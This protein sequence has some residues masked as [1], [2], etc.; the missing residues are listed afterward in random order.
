ML[1]LDFTKLI[2]DDLLT[3]IIIGFISMISLAGGLAFGLGGK[4]MAKNILEKF[5]K[6]D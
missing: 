4:D 2:K 1:V 6:D 3:I 5:N